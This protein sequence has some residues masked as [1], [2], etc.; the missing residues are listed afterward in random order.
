MGKYKV[1]VY[2]ICKNEEQFAARWMRS[3]QEADNVYVLDTG[4]SDRT[5]EKLLSLGAHVTQ[6]IIAPFRFDTARNRS[7][8]LVPPDGDI[9]VCTDL[10]ECFLPGWRQ[11]VED[12]WAQ[13]ADQLRY[14][15]V[16]NFTETGQED[17]VFY[18]DKIHAR[19]GFSWVHPVHEVLQ[20]DLGTPRRA[21]AAGVQLNHYP[22]PQ[23]SRAQYLPLLELSV[24]ECPDNDRNMHYLGREYFFHGQWDKCIYTLKQHLALP[25]AA[26][27]DERCAS[28][29]YI[30]R[31][32][33]EKG[34]E[35][36]QE[37]HLLFACG[38]APHLREPWMDLAH[39]A[40]ARMDWPQLLYACE[41]ALKIHDRPRTYMT[42]GAC[43][44]ALPYDL[45]AVACFHLGLKQRAQE[46][47]DAA[48][49]YEPGNE[50]F[51]QNKAWIE[52][53]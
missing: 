32:Y 36:E 51:Q 15:Y 49:A 24:A 37:R 3:M 22:D 43:Y 23:K 19:N 17:T 7:L 6:E 31:A 33:G 48:L 29:R 50:R 25:S 9:C 35:S 46:A 42:E 44:G 8:A 26:W 38:E 4:S 39:F 13:G 12:A 11:K 27:H 30:A 2:A 41:R 34:S 21:L 18:A 5:V 20:F 16:W 52:K 45:L 1:Y 28:H 10:D 40:Y 14:K 47:I 53:M